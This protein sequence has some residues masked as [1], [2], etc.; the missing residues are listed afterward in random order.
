MVRNSSSNL[1][2]PKFNLPSFDRQYQ[3]WTPFFDSNHCICGWFNNINGY[4]EIQL[5]QVLSLGLSFTT[6]FVLTF[7]KHKLQKALKILIDHYDN[8]GL[9]VNTHLSAIF[10]LKPLQGE[11]ASELRK[12]IVAFEENL[13]A[14]QALK[15]DISSRDFVWVHVLTKKLDSESRRQF[16]L[17]I[18]G[19]D[20]QTLQQL[21]DFINRRVQA[22]EVSDPRT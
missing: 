1:K 2:M 11:S 13:M 21:T 16:E 19:I 7:V 15:V 4:K 12:L 6:H 5:S 18:S 17:D 10:N 20:L 9:I 3:N 8:Q 14:I 22:L